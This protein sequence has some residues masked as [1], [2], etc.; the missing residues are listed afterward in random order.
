MKT[1]AFLFLLATLAHSVTANAQYY[2]TSAKHLYYESHNSSNDATHRILSFIERTA[3]S[4]DTLYITQSDSVLPRNGQ[5]KGNTSRQKIAYTHGNTIIYM[6]DETSLYDEMRI[7][8][9]D[10]SQEEE[11]KK[12]FSSKGSVSILLNDRLKKGEKI[13]TSKF[14]I[15]AGP[16]KMTT[17]LNGTYQGLEQIETPAGKF[18]CMKINYTIKATFFLF[19]SETSDVTEWYAKGIGLVKSEEYTSKEKSRTIKTLVDIKDPS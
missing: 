19:F 17:T 1:T 18:D 9:E 6:L 3:A 12:K 2:N 15:K 7:I 10:K 16:V 11:I 14:T 5:T 13:K 8:V 4:N